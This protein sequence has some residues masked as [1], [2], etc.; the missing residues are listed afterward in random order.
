MRI[1]VMGTGP[2][3]VPTFRWLLNAASHEVLALITRP[4]RPAKGRRQ[5]PVNPMRQVAQEH[6]LPVHAPESINDAESLALLRR[7][8]AE[9]LVVCD[10]G[11]ILSPAALA[12]ARLG[13]INLH[14]SLLPKYRGAAPINWALLEGETE[15]GVTL[16]HMTPRLDGGPC[17]VQETVGIGPDETAGEVEARLARMGVDAVRTSLD[18]LQDWNG[19]ETLGKLQDPQ[20]ATRA[21][22]LKK[23][24]G[25]IDW[26]QSAEQIRNRLRG[27]QPWPGVYTHWHAKK[28]PLRLILDWVEVVPGQSTAEAPG[29][30]LASGSDRLWIATGNGVIGIERIQPAGKRTMEIVEFLRGYALPVGDRLGP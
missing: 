11:Q 1:L 4:T 22:R 27:L 6:G 30:I 12:T 9:L 15:T 20:Q 28:Q 18:L 17:L 14:A 26:S 13:G 2:F 19:Q 3:A 24:D 29:T 5:E 21:P 10:Y 25:Q 23:S 7:F 8:D 16:I